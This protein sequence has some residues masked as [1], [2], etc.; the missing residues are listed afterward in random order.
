MR[1]WPGDQHALQRLHPRQLQT[2]RAETLGTVFVDFHMEQG[3]TRQQASRYDVSLSIYRCVSIYSCWHVYSVYAGFCIT[4]FFLLWFFVL[5]SSDCLESKRRLSWYLVVTPCVTSHGYAGQVDSNRRPLGRDVFLYY[6]TFTRTFLSMQPGQ[7]DRNSMFHAVFRQCPSLHMFPFQCVKI[8]VLSWTVKNIALTWS[9]LIL[10][11]M[12]V[13]QDL[14]FISFI[15]SARRFEIL[16]ANWSPPCRILVDDISEWFSIFFLIY[17]R[18]MT[19][20]HTTSFF[21]LCFLL[22]TSLHYIAP[23]NFIQFHAILG[24]FIVVEGSCL[25]RL[26]RCLL[27]FAVLNVVN[28]ASRRVDLI[29]VF[30][31]MRSRMFEATFVL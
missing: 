4:T 25:Q 2:V 27:G 23:I 16:F 11:N 28:A 24:V 22:C 1:K 19:A 20:S 10:G 15:H 3:W 17:R 5:G 8:N 21:R 14:L 18:D 13:S 29:P 6:G 9:F 31:G 30:E 7:W 12:F 26:T